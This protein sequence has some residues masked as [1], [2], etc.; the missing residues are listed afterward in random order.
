MKRRSFI[1]QST[2]AG[3]GLLLGNMRGLAAPL[4]YP[5]VRTPADKRNFTSTAVENAI[6]DKNNGKAVL[7]SPL[8]EGAYRLFVYISDGHNKIATA[9]VPFYVKL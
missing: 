8:T 6:K 9:N 1:Q 2:L 7:T 3:A 5:V 4:Q